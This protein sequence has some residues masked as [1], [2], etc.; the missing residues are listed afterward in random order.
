M[1]KTIFLYRHGQTDY[2]KQGIVQGS[3]VDSSLNE[4]GIQQAKAFFE[5]YHT[6]NFE[7]V[8]TSALKRTHETAAPFI[9]S[10][11]RWEQFA[12]INEMNWGVHEGKHRNAEMRRLY[13]DMM[14]QW[15]QGNFSAKLENGESALEMAERV[16]RFIQHLK[17]RPE[18][19]ILICSH[20]RAMRC[21]VCLMKELPLGEMENQEHHNTGLYKTNFDGSK[22]NFELQNDLTHLL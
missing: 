5:K 14:D 20:G 7:V 3:G 4:T 1:K 6:E 13:Q 16:Q 22:F 18:Q 19:K 8:L 11:I 12:D 17:Q 2:N 15:A 21:I 10:G 9:N